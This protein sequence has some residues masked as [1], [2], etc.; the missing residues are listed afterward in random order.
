MSYTNTPNNVED[1]AEGKRRADGGAAPAAPAA[2][3]DGGSTPAPRAKGGA[4][5]AP[6]LA[7][8]G[9]TSVTARADGGEV[10]RLAD[11]GNAMAATTAPKKRARGGALKS[12]EMEGMKSKHRRLDRPGRKRGGGVGATTSPLSSAAHATQAG[13]HKADADELAR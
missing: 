2:R 10:G 6:A 8:G 12:L 7:D 4:A 3:A 13:D 1:E 11:G 5:P 9:A